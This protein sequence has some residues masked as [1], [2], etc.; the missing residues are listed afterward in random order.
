MLVEVALVELRFFFKYKSQIRYNK[1]RWRNLFSIRTGVTPPSVVLNHQLRGKYTLCQR[2]KVHFAISTFQSNILKRLESQ[3]NAMQTLTSSILNT[4]VTPAGVTSLLLRNRYVDRNRRDNV[5]QHSN[6]ARV[7]AT[8]TT[9]ATPLHPS[10]CTFFQLVAHWLLH[11][12]QL[13]T[14]STALYDDI[15]DDRQSSTKIMRILCCRVFAF[16]ICASISLCTDSLK[17]TRTQYALYV[18]S[19]TLLREENFNRQESR[20]VR[21][22]AQTHI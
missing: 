20:M 21:K 6:D 16:S 13:C 5:P 17:R 1:V 4:S 8:P 10:E 7:T 2:T 12:T 14:C 19:S 22:S 18:A 9:A 11:L 15:N 3:A